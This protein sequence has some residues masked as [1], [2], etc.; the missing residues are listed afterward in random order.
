MIDQCRNCNKSQRNG[1]TCPLIWKD[2]NCR[3]Y[4]P[5]QKKGKGK[6]A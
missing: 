3:G 1:G 5:K 2:N 4:Q 6:D